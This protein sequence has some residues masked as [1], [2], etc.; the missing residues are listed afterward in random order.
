MP[1]TAGASAPDFE[2]LL[3]DGETFRSTSITDVAGSR[4][5]VLVFDPFVFSAIARNW[6]R[7]YDRHGWDEFE[8]VPVYGV[9]GDGPYAVNAFLRR[10][11]SP[12]SIFADYSCEGASAYDLLTER[13]GMGGLE[14]SRRAVFVCD[15]SLTVREAWV[16]EDWISPVPRQD[17]EDA[18]ESL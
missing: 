12:F 15:E 8:G 3:C 4:G 14:T 11:E 10:L 17:L 9:T 6:W 7:R 5:T 2:A 13:E 16:G 18:I 1:P